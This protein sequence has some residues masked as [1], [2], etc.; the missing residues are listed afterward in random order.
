MAW[1]ATGAPPADHIEARCASAFGA[2]SGSA[3]PRSVTRKEHEAQRDCCRAFVL[4]E[5]GRR[6]RGGNAAPFALVEFS[7]ETKTVSLGSRSV[8]AN[9]GALRAVSSG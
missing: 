6:D 1:R 4:G 7:G 3:D 9:L 5:L 8:G 2:D